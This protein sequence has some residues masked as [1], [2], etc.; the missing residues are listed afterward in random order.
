MKN[1]F[2]LCFGDS[3][4]ETTLLA[5][6][7][8]LGILLNLHMCLAHAALPVHVI[9]S[10]CCKVETLDLGVTCFESARKT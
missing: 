8:E 5:P 10:I 3:K 2:V 4:Q 9:H 1:I 6:G 7:S